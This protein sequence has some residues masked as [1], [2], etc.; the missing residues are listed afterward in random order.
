MS[1]AY[2]NMCKLMAKN[3]SRFIYGLIAIYENLWD[4]QISTIRVGK[5]C[6]AM[7]SVPI[8]IFYLIDPVTYCILIR[9]KLLERLISRLKRVIL[10]Y[11]HSCTSVFAPHDG[12]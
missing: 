2:G 7:H 5:I 1:K 12:Q 11:A 9:V 6:H 8:V 4:F 10:K 3:I